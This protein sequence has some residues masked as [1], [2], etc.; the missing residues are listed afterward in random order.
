[1]IADRLQAVVLGAL[2]VV[3]DGSGHQTVTALSSPPVGSYELVIVAQG[4]QFWRVPNQLGPAIAS[5][6][7]QL[8]FDRRGP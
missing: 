7:V 3:T 4:G 6:N 8:H 2:Q 5:Q 1:M